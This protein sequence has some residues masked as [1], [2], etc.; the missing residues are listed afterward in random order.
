MPQDPE[1]CLIG[2]LPPGL[3]RKPPLH[4]AAEV[5]L[6]EPSRP[7]RGPSGRGKTGP[8]TPRPARPASRC[9]SASLRRLPV[10]GKEVLPPPESSRR[11]PISNANAVAGSLIER[12]RR[13][14]LRAPRRSGSNR[15]RIAGRR[16]EPP[17]FRQGRSA[18]LRGECRGGRPF[19][20]LGMPRRAFPTVAR[21]A[22]LSQLIRP[23][24]DATNGVAGGGKC[25][26]AC[27]AAP[28]DRGSRRRSGGRSAGLRPGRA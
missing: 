2:R 3:G 15:P 12:D 22:A 19:A 23:R 8:G 6:A 26:P 20:A 17:V 11:E 1:R 13:T 14:V 18:D 21:A 28:G 9:G 27:R 4:A 24:N 25:L 16:R 5:A 7:G 10:G